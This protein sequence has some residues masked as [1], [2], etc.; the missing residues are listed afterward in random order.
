MTELPHLFSP[1]QIGNV[2]VRNRLMQTGHAKLYTEGGVDTRRNLDYQ[3]ARA[4]GG[5]GLMITG[6]RLIHPS[7]PAGALR[8][9]QGYLREAVA[10]DR[11]MTDAVHERGARIFA[12]LNHF[13]ANAASDAADDLRVLLAPSA[14]GSP[15]FAETPKAM[16]EVDLE[17]AAEG[18]AR[19]AELS[20]EA[21]FD[22][23]EVH[24]A[25]G[26]L[27]NQFLSPLY[28]RRTDRYG[29]S[30][31]ERTT[32]PRQVLETVRAR[33]G[34][35]FVVGIRLSLT[36]FVEGGLDFD[37]AIE[38]VRTLS[39]AQRIDFINTAGGGYHS[40]LQLVMAPA[41]VE[42]G[43][44]LER[45][46]RLKEQVPG[47]PV[48][49]V[50][51]LSDPESAEEMVATGKA[52][53]IAMTRAQIADPNLPEKLRQGRRREIYRC[54][55]GNQSC[56]ARIIRGLPMACTV[57]PEAGREGKFGSQSL[58]PTAEAGRW[59]VIGG[60][61]A[62]MKAA[63]TLA[64]RG[65][66]VRLMEA[67]ERLGGQV[68]AIVRTPRRERYAV[69]VEDLETRLDDLGVEVC[70]GERADASAVEGEGYDGV[71]V[72][73]GAVPDRTGFSPAAPTVE[74]IP[75]VDLPHVLTAP[76][77]IEDVGR[78]G[79]SVL[80]LDG[81]GTR[82]AAGVAE[83]LLDAGRQVT[84]VTRFSS[85]FPGTAATL[86]QSILYR[87]LFGKGLE[88]HLNSWVRRID[89]DAAEVYSLYGG[90]TV[91]L[92]GLGSVVLVTGRVAESALYLDLL[93]RGIEAHRVGDC[94]A[95]RAI[96]H[97]IYEGYLAGREQL[98]SE[99]RYIVEGELE[100]W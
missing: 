32:F 26:Y 77:V 64:R 44:F 2:T 97:A 96:D 69:L 22:G 12:Q 37:D 89:A 14:V 34:D 84:V 49:A 66:R 8:F 30:L 80:V 21:G 58:P 72:A 78:A 24:M 60:G 67:A 53:M 99:E 83:L 16:E 76:E 4:E 46:L 94:V 81:E 19:S 23:V 3:V 36:E 70:L 82:A 15:A 31:A 62:G 33:V 25:H 56:V 11:R 17:A 63:E 86:D 50:G 74:R 18:W 42:S 38:V 68:N 87:E 90:A 95:P 55:R 92:D 85:L 20:R 10:G 9:S 7:S 71:I 6:N 29:G 1:C 13:G 47:I 88:Y 35:D 75:G 48:F 93:A 39:A 43:W 40:G 5:I 52:D 54:I 100:R 91:K 27:L 73:T 79:R 61:P 57:N 51:G 28:N 41:D 59:L 45:A 65:H 98:D